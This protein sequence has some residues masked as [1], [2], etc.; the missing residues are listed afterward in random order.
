MV[1]EGSDLYFLVDRSGSMAGEKWARTADAL[2][3]F[4]KAITQHDRVWI[5]FFE[6]NYRDFAEKPLGR[7]GLLRDPNFQSLA[8][9][10]T[11]GGTELLPAL[12]HVLGVHQRF[13]ARRRSHIV[14][15]TDGQVA[16]EEAVLKEVSGAVVPVHCF[17][18]DHAVN[19]AFLRQLSEQQRGTS[20]FLTPNDDLVRPVAILGSRLSRPVLTQLTLDGDWE[21]AGTELPDIYVGQVAFAPVR[22]K[23]NRSDFKVAGRDSAGRPLTVQLHEQ[24]VKTD[25]PKL[26]WMKRRI[27]SFL[28]A[29]NVKEAIALAEKANLVCRGT[30]FIAWDDTE[31]VAIAQAEVYQPS[32]DVPRGVPSSGYSMPRAAFM[33]AA[34]PS[35][36]PGKAKD[37]PRGV[38]SS[39][40]S[41]PQ[42][43][44]M[45][46]A[47]RSF[48]PA[49][50]KSL[51]DGRPSSLKSKLIGWWKPVPRRLTERLNGT[52]ESVFCADDA[53]KLTSIVL[54]WAKYVDGKK[55]TNTLRPLL[56]EC[57][58]QENALFLRKV[59]SKFFLSLP[60]PWRTRAS[61][62]LSASTNK[63]GGGTVATSG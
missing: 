3:A 49:K 13:S 62:I 5:T 63:S 56:R 20:V 22:T 25:L 44:F 39:G 33:P 34:S 59:V 48:M 47:S 31:Q 54:D 6:S 17:G 26:I 42:V 30:A 8:R 41:T 15:I 36:M 43:A 46:A 38:P 21:L 58:R 60:D 53:T 55:I 35:F 40:H 32:L 37:V 19:E 12:S 51:P 52:I 11:G 16:N 57:E 29:G 50:T 7:D 10:G 28:Q 18:I 24:A 23:G 61:S 27:E 45:P 1:P 2:I 14:L 4:V 9:L